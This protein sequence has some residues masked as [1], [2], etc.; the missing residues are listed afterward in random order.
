M[1]I[2]FMQDVFFYFH[3]R[4]CSL[5]EPQLIVVMAN[6]HE[7]CA[8]GIKILSDRQQRA[9]AFLSRRTPPQRLPCGVA[10]TKWLEDLHQEGEFFACVD[11][12]DDFC[13]QAIGKQHEKTLAVTNAMVLQG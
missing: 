1:F 11:R 2:F 10:V 8:F 5:Q 4:G 9:T 13:G 3:I 6:V 12:A 7:L